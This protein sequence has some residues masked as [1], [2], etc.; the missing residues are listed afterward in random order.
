[1][2]RNKLFI[3]G[4]L[5]LA[6]LLRLQNINWDEG[7]HLHPDE[8]F[9]TMVGNAMKLPTVFLDYFDPSGSSLNPVNVGYSFFVYG[10]FP[11][12]LNKIL[13][14]LL[15][16]DSYHMFTL[17][18]RLLSGLFDIGIVF[19]LYKLVLLLQKK[20]R[21]PGALKY[22]APF[23]YVTS[24]YPIQISHFFT[25]D[26]FLS[27]FLFMSLYMAFLFHY[28]KKFTHLM[29]ASI[30][31]GLA[32][33]SKISAVY[34]LPLIMFVV[35]FTPLKERKWKNIIFYG[36]LF[37]T[38]TYLSIRIFNPYYFEN[39][40]IF[41]FKINATFLKNISD[42]KAM[43]D[44]KVWFP[45]AVQWY[46][47]SPLLFSLFNLV[48][49]GFGFF[50]FLC[51]IYGFV[52]AWMIYRK[53]H[54][55]I[56]FTI[57]SAL[58]IVGYFLY[59]SVQYVKSLRYLIFIFPILSFYAGLGVVELIRKKN[60]IF[61]SLTIMLLLVWPLIFSSIYLLRNTRIEAS[62]WIYEHIPNGARILT[63]YWDDPL[64]L[65]VSDTKGKIFNVIQIPVFDPDTTNKW[66]ALDLEFKTSDYYILSSNR[67]W[68][69]IPTVPEK[70]PKMSRYYKDLFDGK[71][72]FK[73]EKRFVPAY[74][75]F[76][77]FHPSSWIN[78]W[79]EE[80]FTVYDHP[81]VFIFKKK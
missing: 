50:H 81:S 48:F 17:Q 75:E 40:N 74:Q 21:L 77:P 57:F 59:N 33:A 43:S 70:Y 35:F 15:G 51:A 4:I 18:G 32:F 12:V 34:M 20:E 67:G 9:L 19:I 66:A 36:I 37:S 13:A 47:K 56:L 71:T 79:V 80:L 25:T 14:V 2:K 45:P 30:C 52:K 31:L 63:E 41:N 27:F 72:S 64:P 61:I 29:Y 8:R 76:F 53:Q 16:N 24:V 3:V 46:T 62:E 38:I 60:K 73:L 11:L 5:L 69:S 55:F 42:L 39:E 6:V 65:P 49:V 1:M 54:F 10:I 44:G 23:M 22:V 58:W 7:F 26:T 68:G 78:Q 28:E